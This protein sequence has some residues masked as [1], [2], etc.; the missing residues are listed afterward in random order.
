MSKRAIVTYCVLGGLT[1]VFAAAG[2][3]GAI[4]IVEARMRAFEITQVV[5]T[6]PREPEGIQRATALMFAWTIISTTVAIAT[7]RWRRKVDPSLRVV[8]AYFLIPV[9]ILAGYIVLRTYQM[10]EL[11]ETSEVS[12]PMI[13]LASLGPGTEEARLVGFVSVVLWIFIGTRKPAKF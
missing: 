6:S 12:R 3:F 8:V 1:L 9:V 7:H 5:V 2:Y 11:F 10:S 13:S 4:A